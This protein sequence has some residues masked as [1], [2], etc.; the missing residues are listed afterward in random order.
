MLPA[1]G[2][3]TLPY[4]P[5]LL[6]SPPSIS[7]SSSQTLDPTPAQKNVSP[8]RVK[9]ALERPL[10]VVS[11]SGEPLGTINL[12]VFLR[13]VYQYLNDIKCP[14]KHFDATGGAVAYLISPQNAKKYADLEG[15][16]NPIYPSSTG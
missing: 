16:S 14:P 5:I 3:T 6:K 13:H 12:P 4:Q 10:H 1:T 11:K 8:A 9:A 15:I 2:K 7:P